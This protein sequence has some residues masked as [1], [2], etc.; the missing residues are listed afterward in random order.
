M[1]LF[2]RLYFPSPEVNS[3]VF[4]EDSY[5]KEWEENILLTL[6]EE[7]LASLVLEAAAEEAEYINPVQKSKISWSFAIIATTYTGVR[8]QKEKWGI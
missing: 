3:F 6:S 1:C 4:R 5:W 2:I 8:L 7:E